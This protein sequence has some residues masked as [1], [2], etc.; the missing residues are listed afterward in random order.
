VAVARGKG[1][2]QNIAD[3]GEEGEADDG[4]VITPKKPSQV[5]ITMRISGASASGALSVFWP[6]SSS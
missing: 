3:T 1:S 6:T 2:T 4:E 5:T